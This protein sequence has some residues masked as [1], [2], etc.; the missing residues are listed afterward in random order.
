MLECIALHLAGDN[1]CACLHHV[2]VL[3]VFMGSSID[4]VTAEAEMMFT[5]VRHACTML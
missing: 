1:V 5:A 4:T 2:F 3:Q